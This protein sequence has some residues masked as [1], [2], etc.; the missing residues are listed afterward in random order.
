MFRTISLSL[1]FA[2]LIACTKT[3][4]TNLDNTELKAM[5][6][7]G[8]PIV[9][10]R[11]PEEWRQTGVISDSKRITF[12]DGNGR[13]HPDFLN[14]FTSTIKKNEAVILICRTGNRTDVLARLLIEKLGYSR[15]YNVKHGITRW[16]KEGKPTKR[17]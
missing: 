17:I 15:I 12:V 4:Y 14:H 16:I 1:L 8:V 13:L 7:Q 3:P 5:L 9:D 11:R 10:I 6:E 2:M